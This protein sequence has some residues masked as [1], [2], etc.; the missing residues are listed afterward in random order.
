MLAMGALAVTIVLAVVFAPQV[1]NDMETAVTSTLGVLMAVLVL[2]QIGVGAAANILLVAQVAPAISGE[3]E[4][5]SWGLLRSTTLPLREIM[6]AKLVAIFTQMR[7][8]LAGLL[9]LRV[10]STGTGLLLVAYLLRESFYYDPTGREEF[11]GSGQWVM[12][13]LALALFTIWYLAQPAVQFG[14]NGAVAL[15]AS[16][17]ARSRARAIAAALAARMAGWVLSALVNGGLIYGLG[18]LLIANWASPYSAPLRAFRDRPT[19]SEEMIAF[20]LG[21]TAALYVLGVLAAQLGLT[22]GA[23]ALAQRI[24][25]RL[26]A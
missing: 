14:L 1:Y 16:A 21:S 25:R 26:G 10:A 23:L 18:Y 17:S 9:A 7:G 6:L 22:V 5:Q 12:P 24:A 13:G 3:V 20:V 4:L 11:F 19:P 8:A 15:L 2:I